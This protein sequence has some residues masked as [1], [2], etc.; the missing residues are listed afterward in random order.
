M[1]TINEVVNTVAYSRE[2]AYIKKEFDYS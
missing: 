2:K 1:A